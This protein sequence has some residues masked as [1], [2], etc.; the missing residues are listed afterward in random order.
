MEEGKSE[1]DEG[2]R[3]GGRKEGRE[4]EGREMAT[5]RSDTVSDLGKCLGKTG[6]IGTLILSL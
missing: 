5:C 4:E 6:R 2:K 3:M 1:R